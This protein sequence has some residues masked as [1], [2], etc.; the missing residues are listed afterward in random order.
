M[1]KTTNLLRLGVGKEINTSR[2]LKFIFEFAFLKRLNDN[3][4][5]DFSSNF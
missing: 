5:E 4:Y 3:G 1:N 2:H